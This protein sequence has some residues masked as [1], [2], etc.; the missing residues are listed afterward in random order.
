MFAQISLK[1]VLTVINEEIG[2]IAAGTVMEFFLERLGTFI[3]NKSLD[4]AKLW[5]SKR[6]EDI[7]AD[8]DILYK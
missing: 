8:F 6:M 3:Y 4:D 7:E 5:F 1:T 2:I